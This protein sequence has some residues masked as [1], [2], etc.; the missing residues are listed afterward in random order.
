MPSI[1]DL[2][3]TL[4]RRS[5]V[6]VVDDAQAWRIVT[7]KD[8][9][10]TCEITVPREVL[11]WHAC[12]KHSSSPDEEWSDWMDYSGYDDRAMEELESEMA[13]DILA[14]VERAASSRLRPPSRIW[15]EQT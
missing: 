7:T 4:R 6:E 15:D 9:G 8:A 2:I 5:D 10:W 11:E 1:R 3:E 12:V 13:G 14:L